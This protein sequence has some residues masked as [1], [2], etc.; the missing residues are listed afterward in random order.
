MPLH[1]QPKGIAVARLRPFDSAAVVF[2]HP[3]FRLRELATVRRVLD[4][5]GRVLGRL[6][7]L[8]G[9]A[10]QS[11]NSSSRAVESPQTQSGS[12]DRGNPRRSRRRYARAEVGR[13]A[14]RTPIW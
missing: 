8:T 7:G 6:G 10:N 11:K 5:L 9:T 3:S 1:E 14:R 12:R 2:F 13:V 4:Y